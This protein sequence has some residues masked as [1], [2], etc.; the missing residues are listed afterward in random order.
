MLSELLAVPERRAC[1]AL[2]VMSTRLR[3]RNLAGSELVAWMRWPPT[4]FG[5]ETQKR[6]FRRETGRKRNPES[7]IP[8]PGLYACPSRARTLDSVG[9]WVL[10]SAIMPWTL[11]G[12]M[13]IMWAVAGFASMGMRLEADSSFLS[14]STRP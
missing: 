4:A 14:A 1:R 9:G 3:S 12:F 8:N 2:P 6:S 5:A 10:N 13:I 11:N 7:R